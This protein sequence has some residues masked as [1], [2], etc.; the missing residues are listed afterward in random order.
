MENVN[1]ING[2]NALALP[3]LVALGREYE[4]H[5][6]ERI[7]AVSQ[8]LREEGESY[9]E[10]SLDD[11]AYEIRAAISET[12][13]H[14]KANEDDDEC[15]H[16]IPAIE[17]F[18]TLYQAYGHNWADE[19]LRDYLVCVVCKEHENPFESVAYVLAHYKETVGK[20][21]PLNSGCGTIASLVVEPML[22]SE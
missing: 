19:A 18:F 17:N 12:I 1:R 4:A 20:T 3:F 21:M 5:R 22:V 9:S 16:G 8:L 7:A 10:Q 2:M 13:G 6:G 15:Q 11:I 14:K